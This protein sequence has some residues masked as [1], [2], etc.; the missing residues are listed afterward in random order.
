MYPF[1][2]HSKGPAPGFA[3]A[4]ASPKNFL[5][6][7]VEKAYDVRVDVVVTTTVTARLLRLS[8]IFSFGTEREEAISGMIESLCSTAS[9]VGTS[10]HLIQSALFDVR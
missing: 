2:K 10:L 5:T 1:G 7:V 3:G 4:T 9:T 8:Y 6:V